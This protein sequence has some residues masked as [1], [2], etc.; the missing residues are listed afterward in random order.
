[1]YR[2][3]ARFILFGTSAKKGELGIVTCGITG[4]P[5]GKPSIA[6]ALFCS[7]PSVHPLPPDEG[8]VGVEYRWLENLRTE[9]AL[10]DIQ[11]L[12]G[13]G[14]VISVVN[15]P[16][17]RWLISDEIKSRRA[18]VPAVVDDFL[19]TTPTYKRIETKGSDSR[20]SLQLLCGDN[21][22]ILSITTAVRGHFQLMIG[23]ADCLAY[24][25]ERHPHQRW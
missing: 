3:R 4:M 21:R 24:L 10:L 25:P 17:K 20:N 16:V 2:K 7:V 19:S 18:R 8:R 15:S 22:S 14:H 11:H 23:R 9:I 6:A 12:A 1:M 13:S 5:T